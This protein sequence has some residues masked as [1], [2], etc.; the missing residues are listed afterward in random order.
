MPTSPKVG[1]QTSKADI[2]THVKT[3][4]DVLIGAISD[5]DFRELAMNAAGDLLEEPELVKGHKV[6]KYVPMLTL[7]RLRL[8]TTIAGQEILASFQTPLLRVTHRVPHWS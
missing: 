2:C 8:L 4:R 7:Q 1:S 3:A 6:E 5:A